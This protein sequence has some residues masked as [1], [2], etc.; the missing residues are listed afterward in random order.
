M[1]VLVTGTSGFVGR[2]L[3]KRCLSDGW[4]VTALTRQ[5]ASG[6]TPELKTHVIA[7]MEQLGDVSGALQGQDVVVHCAARVHVMKEQCGDPLAA[8]RAVNVAGTLELARQAA[9]AGVQRFIYLSSIKV[10]GES[11]LPGQPF[12]ENDQLRPQDAYAK[13]KHE[14][15]IGLRKIAAQT[16][17]EVVIIRPPLVYGQG[18]GANFKAVMTAIYRGWPLPLGGLDNRRSLVSVDNLVDLVSVCMLHPGAVNQTFLV[19]DGDDLSTSQL[20]RHLAQS[21]GRP[22][23]LLSVPVPILVLA[24]RLL[25]RS[26]AADR[27]CGSLQVDIGKASKLLSWKPPVCVEQGL[28]TT[29]QGYLRETSL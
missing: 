9:E 29:A 3:V 22:A 18:V 20:V 5:T 21:L 26:A 27:L 10:H 12:T 6:V 15:E 7:G 1:R 4:Q 23:R 24:A 14:A 13:S 2:H 19:S 28:Q 25:G 8:F 11:T 17:M 16:S